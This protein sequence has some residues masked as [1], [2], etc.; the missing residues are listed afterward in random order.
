[1]AF[2][3][4]GCSGGP[5]SNEE[6]GEFRDALERDDVEVV[7]RWLD[8]G[9]SPDFGTRAL[10]FPARGPLCESALGQAAAA[11][12]AATVRLLLER[13]AEPNASAD[14]CGNTAM[15]CTS[16]DEVR[17][18]L[19]SQGGALSTFTDCKD[20]N[21]TL[22]VGMSLDE[23]RDPMRQVEG[24]LILDTPDCFSARLISEAGSFL[25]RFERPDDVSRPDDVADLTT[26]EIRRMSAEPLD[27]L[28]VFG[29]YRNYPGRATR[30]NALSLL[31]FGCGA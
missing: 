18:I 8:D 10:G 27:G 1:M 17:V 21:Q 19:E 22:R 6:I 31:I 20:P 24:E 3:A 7:R 26:D 2:A 28:R 23:A 25:V 16:T 9:L 15:A 11:G 29:G 5:P 14:S 13:G 30:L 12:S 4:T